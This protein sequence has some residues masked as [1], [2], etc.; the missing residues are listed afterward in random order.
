MSET[1]FQVSPLL[2][3]MAKADSSHGVTAPVAQHKYQV[4][5]LS[6][7]SPPVATNAS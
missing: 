4:V 1:W 5:P 3:L 2:R 7:P 6:V